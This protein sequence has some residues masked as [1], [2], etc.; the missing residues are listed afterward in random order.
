MYPRLTVV[1]AGPAC[2]IQDSGRFGYL[3]YGVT[4]SGPMDW[5]AH[6]MANRA[7]RNPP[8][9]GCIEA[10]PGG[11]VLRADVAPVR[12]GLAAPGFAALRD[13][14]P[15][16]ACGR[17]TLRPGETLAIL[18]GAAGVWAYVAVAGGFGLAEALGSVSTSL[19]ARLGPFGG[20]GLRAGDRLRCRQRASAHLPDAPL[21]ALP[22]G[23]GVIRFVPG[24]QAEAVT[25][26]SLDEFCA[27]A[28]AVAPRSDRMAMRL[29]GPRLTHSAGHDIVS[30]G[31]AMG[32]IQVP[33]DGL[34]LVLMADRQPTGGYPKIGTVIRADLPAL[35]Q[36]R[37]GHRVRFAMT[38]VA[39]AVEALR[40][41]L[42]QV[43]A[44][45]ATKDGPG[46]TAGK[47]EV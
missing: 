7:V 3:R 32:A 38:G 42:L 27:A 36:T 31:I 39:A 29:T 22:A 17:V 26:E 37:T 15:V 25:A 11:I 19:R 45:A 40:A 5:M 8:G 24:P 20:R 1:A 41:A 35:A 9:G 13:G 12:L 23:P 43:D 33:G 4:P 28:Y 10:G 16:P 14:R 47:A 44:L 2:T 46:G 34:P 30:D 18:P 6:R 21:P